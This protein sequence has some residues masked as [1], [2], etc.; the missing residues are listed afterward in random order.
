MLEEIY[1]THMMPS[2]WIWPATVKTWTGKQHRHRYFDRRNV[3]SSASSKQKY[4]KQSELYVSLVVISIEKSE[5]SYTI[6]MTWQWVI[7]IS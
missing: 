5:N 2:R 6:L 1:V 4:K 7:D 3:F